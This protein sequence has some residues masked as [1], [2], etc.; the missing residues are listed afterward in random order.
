[1]QYF[2]ARPFCLTSMDTHPPICYSATSVAQHA[3]V[4]VIIPI[5]GCSSRG[6]LPGLTL[7]SGPGS[8]FVHQLSTRED[9]MPAKR[10]ACVTTR[11]LSFWE[12]R[13]RVL[14]EFAGM[15]AFL[16]KMNLVQRLVIRFLNDDYRGRTE[17]RPAPGVTAPQWPAWLRPIAG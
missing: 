3:T 13:D 2:L 17:A 16:P 12:I 10:L 1:M 9:F 6:A 4:N 14:V 8:F 7:G 15:H 11:E 5:Y